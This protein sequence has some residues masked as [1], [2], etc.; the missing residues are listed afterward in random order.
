MKKALLIILL[1]VIL[2]IFMFVMVDQYTKFALK[3]AT[4]KLVKE[5]CNEDVKVR[6]VR[7]SRMNFNWLNGPNQKWSV[8]TNPP[9]YELNGY[10]TQGNYIPNL[11][12]PLPSEGCYENIKI[13]MKL[14]RYKRE[15]VP[16]KTPLMI[17]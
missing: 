12:G 17:K 5:Y 7:I 4:I 16:A 6:E 3:T 10:I 9:V 13:S 15:F 1:V 8:I 2:I 14:D 11:W